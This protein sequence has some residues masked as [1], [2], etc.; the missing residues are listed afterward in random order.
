MVEKGKPPL[1]DASK[2]APPDSGLLDA[3]NMPPYIEVK[4]P[5]ADKAA[6]LFVQVLDKVLDNLSSGK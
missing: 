1:Y 2:S 3:R 5:L 6:G 4:Q